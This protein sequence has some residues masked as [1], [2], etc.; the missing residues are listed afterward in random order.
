MSE[1]RSWD[2][3]LTQAQ[4]SERSFLSSVYFWMS[5]G[6]AMTGGVAW[7]MS[8]NPSA[9]VSLMSNRGLILILVLLQLGLVIGLSA[10][11]TRINLGVAVLGFGAYACL[12]GVIF[13]SIF[14]IYTAVSIGTTFFVTA[15]TF[16]AISLYGMTTKRDLSSVG[17]LAFMGLIGIIIASLVNWFFQN[18]ILYWAVT[19]VGIAVFIGLT[20]YDT[21]KLKRIHEQ[22]FAEGEAL[23]K[24]ALLGALKLYLDFIN[25]FLF[26]LRILGRRK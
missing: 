26:L 11:I 24:M 19:Y 2:L 22:G 6:L 5:M 1:N 17:N 21:Q 15:G 8:L 12:N 3:E 16:A 20:A 4:V 23:Q 13:S 14:L 18:P 10:A 25:L 7:W 9:V